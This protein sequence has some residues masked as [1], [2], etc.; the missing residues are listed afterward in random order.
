MR[1][2]DRKRGGKG[3]SPTGGEE[4]SRPAGGGGEGWERRGGWPTPE[5]KGRTR[6]GEWAGGCCRQKG[7]D[8]TIHP[9]VSRDARA[10]R[11]A[12]TRSSLGTDAPPCVLYAHGGAAGPLTPSAAAVCLPPQTP[13]PSPSAS[14]PT[15]PQRR[16]GRR[17]PT[18]AERCGESLV[19][20][21]PIAPSTA[22]TIYAAPFPPLPPPPPPGPH[23]FCAVAVSS[24]HIPTL[25]TATAS[26]PCRPP[27]WGR[28]LPPRPD[29]RADG[30]G[31]PQ[32]QWRRLWRW[33][34][35]QPRRPVAE[36]RRKPTERLRRS[37]P[38]PTAVTAAFLP[39]PR[40]IMAWCHT[41]GWGKGRNRGAPPR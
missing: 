18:V 7:D 1:G 23:C 28:V 39:T 24:R 31:C 19:C 8:H 32:R 17:R 34:Q 20:P 14:R 15:E 3:N 13:R 11:G 22:T 16:L 26:R 4:R 25:C 38:P 2:G 6:V 41:W 33:T 40:A 21:P 12:S 9:D 36:R 10:T 29:G 5:D 30:P 27:Q 37:P 35:L